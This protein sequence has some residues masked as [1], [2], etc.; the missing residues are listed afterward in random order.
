MLL[1][2]ETARLKLKYAAEALPNQEVTGFGRLEDAGNGNQRLIDIIIPP[3]KV[4]S[5]HVDIEPEVRDAFLT[6]VLNQ[7]MDPKEWRVWWHKHPGTTKPTPSGTDEK[8]LEE[9]AASPK[10]NG[11]GFGWMI[12]VIISSDA[13]N[14]Y[15]WLSEATGPWP[16]EQ[17]DIPIRY[18]A[19]ED[20]RVRAQIAEQ[21]KRVKVET[22]A[23]GSYTASSSNHGFSHTK[24][25]IHYWHN[26]KSGRMW[27]N[28]T[29]LY[30]GEAPSAEELAKAMEK[31]L[32]KQDGGGAGWS[33]SQG[34][35][36]EIR[37]STTHPGMVEIIK[38]DG[39]VILTKDTGQAETWAKGVGKRQAPIMPDR[40]TPV[41][42]C[43]KQCDARRP[44]AAARR[45]MQ[46][47][48][49]AKRMAD[50]ENR[51]LTTKP[52]IGFD[53]D[54]VPVLVGQEWAMHFG[55]DQKPVPLEFRMNFLTQRAT[56]DDKCIGFNMKG[57]RLYE[58]DEHSLVFGVDGSPIFESN[59]DF[60]KA[61]RKE[62]NVP[63]VIQDEDI[64]EWFR[65]FAAP[66]GQLS[67]PAGLGWS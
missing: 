10:D 44:T 64:L 49:K 8:T 60:V 29:R 48:V 42:S 36:K 35:V 15:G 25:G 22:P 17:K 21:M 43:N 1:I 26:Y 34:V 54:G 66:D 24:D 9:F 27:D 58:G 3:Q 13:S 31:E 61:L 67:M 19:R 4:G 59:E 28:A 40:K 5:A 41:H 6:E 39:V 32:A 11:Y 50:A 7:G 62:H 47:Y 2:S 51:K 56:N 46:R 65:M 12:G 55:L 37:K 30:K 38:T 18:E 53:F 20:R 16:L 57:D 63:D 45:E 52:V 14:I 23:Y 33:K